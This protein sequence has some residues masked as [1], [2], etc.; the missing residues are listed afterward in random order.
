MKKNN[1]NYR[2]GFGA[3][4]DKKDKRDYLAAG[5]TPSTTVELKEFRIP[6]KYPS[7]NQG[8]RGSCTSQAQ[9]HHK[10][11][12]EKIPLSARFVMAL[13]KQIEGNKRWGAYTRNTFKVVNK[14]GACREELYPEPN[15][16]MTW[17]DYI[18]TKELLGEYYKDALKH[19][20]KSYW[21]V[22]N[23]IL[24]IK[25][26]L[27]LHNKSV[28]M[29]MGWYKNFNRVLDGILPRE[30]GKYISGHAV[31]IVGFNDFNH[32]LIVKNSWGEKWGKKGDFY[33]D[34]DMFP[35]VIRD[36]WC[37]LDIEETDIL[38]DERYGKKRTWKSY[39]VEKQ[40]AFN[41]WLHA[42]IKRLP[43][44]REINALAYGKWDFQTVYTGINGDIW[45]YWT[46]DQ[47][48]KRNL[49]KEFI[50]Y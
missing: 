30:K 9:T 11:R 49:I 5:I 29:S 48:E 35:K 26:V 28:V 32:W 47:A 2:Y 45:L 36:L 15:F 37:S 31:E 8:G 39:L 34:Y 42:K 44:N 33:L 46:K 43:T 20:S 50:K 21:R 40:V 17:I 10:E 14:Y 12:Q 6:E 38:V 16:E 24:A 25:D 22:E 19:K 13:T 41:S 27:A 4:K 23:S 18:D 3:K 1:L 7:K